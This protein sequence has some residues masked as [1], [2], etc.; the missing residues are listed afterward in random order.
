[1]QISTE[2]L[3]HTG[4]SEYLGC[5]LNPE[6][7]PMKRTL[8]PGF[9][10][11]IAGIFCSAAC[12]KSTDFVAANTNVD[13]HVNRHDT[14][15]TS[16]NTTGHPYPTILGQQCVYSPDYGDS[17]IYSQPSG[18]DY[19]I[20]PQNTQ[21]NQ[22]TYL[23]WPAGL[24]IDA[25]TGTIN[26][27]LSQTGQRYDIAFVKSGTTDTCISQLIVAGSSYMDSVHVITFGTETASPYFNANPAVP[28][29]C[30]QGSSGIGCS[31]DYNG[32]AKGQGIDIDKKTGI[33]HLKNT[34]DKIFGTNPVN[35]MTVNTTIF[36]TMNDNSNNAPQQMPLRFIYYDRV[37]D[38]PPALLATITSRLNS[39]NN[40]QLLTKGPA[41]VRPPLII[42]VRAS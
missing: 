2:T 36:Y 16:V 9:I 30:Q 40:N 22:G 17:V 32:F 3:A 4:F 11:L 6:S 31:F 29:P 5:C 39:A 41:T 27:T 42:I 7:V 25:N 19:F 10:I 33:I 20:S 12:K 23:S 24:I 18:G 37:S 35:G 13:T 34:A 28:S 26:L 21:G 14:S 8:P 38:I 1:M 15:T